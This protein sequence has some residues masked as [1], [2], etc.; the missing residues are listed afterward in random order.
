MSDDLSLDDVLRAYAMGLFP[1]AESRDD[2]GFWWFDPPM[3]GQLDITGLH[4]P[5]SLRKSVLKAP[6]EIRID[7]AFANVIDACAEARSTQAETWINKPIRDIFVRLHEAGFTHSVEAW[8]GD[9]LVGGLYGLALGGAFCGESMFSRERDASKICLVHL[10]ARLWRGG[11]S[12]LDTQYVND[13]LTQFG[14]YEVDSATY[15]QRLDAALLLPADF[16]LRSQPRLSE[17]FLVRE[18]LQNRKSGN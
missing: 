5:N 17:E 4:I 3:R 11:F 15:K 2:E 13:H 16:S 7:T 12:L 8:Q 18:Y 6:Y 9:K 1:M 10:C 14:C